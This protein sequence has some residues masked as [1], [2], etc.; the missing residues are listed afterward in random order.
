MHTDLQRKAAKAAA[1]LAPIPLL[2][3]LNKGEMMYQTLLFDMDGTVLDTLGDL[4][5]AINYTM[6]QY[7]EPEHTIDEIRSYVGNGVVKLLERSIPNGHEAKNF[8]E[9]M[10]TY[11]DYYAIHDRDLTKPYD[12]ILEL[13]EW[14]RQQ[15]IR[16]GIVSNKHHS[17]V[18]ELSEHFFGDLVDAA[19]GNKP[20]GK[21][22]PDPTVVFDVMDELS[23]EPGTTVY[24]GDSDVD[25]ATAANAGLDC[26]LVSWG[27]RPKELLLE[28]KAKAVVDSVDEL[29][30]AISS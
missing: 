12:G 20:G 27:F 6:R 15:G 22:K 19:A 10:K 29:K 7:G 8:D 18:V 21:T 11:Q 14:A 5:A 28:Q 26:I 4:T 2:A 17:A 1:N 24:I 30:R 13:M 25:A 3:E 9:Q 23:A 16:I